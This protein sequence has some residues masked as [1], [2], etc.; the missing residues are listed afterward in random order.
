M[1]VLVVVACTSACRVI[2]WSMCTWYSCGT[3]RRCLQPTE[4]LCFLPAPPHSALRTPQ[5][6]KNVRDTSF[7]IKL[8]Q[9]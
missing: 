9:P 6:G 8:V 7:K 2:V 5:S 1:R 3:L 4:I